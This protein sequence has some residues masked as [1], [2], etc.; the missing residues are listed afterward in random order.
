MG[1]T[2]NINAVGERMYDRRKRIP[3]GNTHDVGIRCNWPIGVH[4]LCTYIGFP[5]VCARMQDR[6]EC[7]RYR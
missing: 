6:S 3:V 5:R 7:S 2:R 1:K 4:G